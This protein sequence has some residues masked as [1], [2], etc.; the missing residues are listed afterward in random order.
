VQ[1]GV[2]GDRHQLR[3]TCE[4]GVQLGTTECSP[5]EIAWD[6]CVKEVQLDPGAGQRLLKIINNKTLAANLECM[7]KTAFDNFSEFSR[8]KVWGILDTLEEMVA[9]EH[10]KALT[11]FD[12]TMDV[13]SDISTAV[14]R[15]LQVVGM[16]EITYKD[17][18]PG[19][20]SIQMV[21]SL[22]SQ[23]A[24]V[25]FCVMS[26]LDEGAYQAANQQE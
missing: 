4:D 11:S 12:F 2:G 16:Y 17:V 22:C 13:S 18:H 3:E 6:R 10:L 8:R 19:S 15:V 9:C 26:E 20:T 24:S 21:Y 7:A 5:H 1:L 25:V 23:A 14:A